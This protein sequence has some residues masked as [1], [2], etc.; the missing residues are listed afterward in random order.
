MQ[1]HPLFYISSRTFEIKRREEKADSI[2]TQ[3]GTVREKMHFQSKTVSTC[4]N[5]PRA[6][7]VNAAAA[8]QSIK[9]VVCSE[10]GDE[11]KI[12]CWLNAKCWTAAGKYKREK[13]IF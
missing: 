5:T 7:V 12:S 8:A 10:R 3:T 11:N 9:S 13:E 4:A 2:L 1:R 6:V